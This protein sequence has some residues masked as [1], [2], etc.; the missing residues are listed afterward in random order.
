M[1]RSRLLLALG[2]VI[3]GLGLLSAG[4][5]ASPAHAAADGLFIDCEP[6]GTT[7]ADL[8]CNVA[9]TDS[10]DADSDDETF[11]GTVVFTSSITSNFTISP[12][13]GVGNEKR[14]TFKAGDLTDGAADG[15]DFILRF[16]NPGTGTVTIGTTG[17]ADA[18]SDTI[19]I[20]GDPVTTTTTAAPTTTTTVAGATTTTVAGSVITT[21]T[22]ASAGTTSTTK[23][24]T[25]TV[26]SGALPANTGSNSSREAQVAG[27][28]LGLG[29]LLM[30]AA[31]RRTMRARGDHFLG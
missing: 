5:G 3:S 21:T 7:G 9:A 8:A 30:V 4:P 13:D 29:A 19:V 11:R 16:N 18:E 27:G 26:R 22:L 23:A 2:L 12:N 28:L 25:T 14:Y 1:R 17:I 24:T 15:K 31:S 10:A 6:T 20:T